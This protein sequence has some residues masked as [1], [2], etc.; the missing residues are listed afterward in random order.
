MRDSAG[1]FIVKKAKIFRGYV[2]VKKSVYVA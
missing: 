2:K 1:R